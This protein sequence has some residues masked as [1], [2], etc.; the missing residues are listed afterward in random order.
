M[1]RI[2][3]AVE[4]QSIETVVETNVQTVSPVPPYEFVGIKSF[5]RFKEYLNEQ[6]PPNAFPL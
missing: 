3:F 6:L 1:G 2:S 5:R 4:I